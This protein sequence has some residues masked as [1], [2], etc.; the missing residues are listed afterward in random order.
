M[1]GDYTIRYDIGDAQSPAG[2]A[3]EVRRLELLTEE[4]IRMEE[5]EDRI[6]KEEERLR[7]E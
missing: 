6:R 2:V 7:Q 5:H 4:R 1:E 3:L